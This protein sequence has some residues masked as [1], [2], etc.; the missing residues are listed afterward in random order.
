MTQP[1]ALSLSHE[2]ADA[3]IA[4]IFTFPGRVTLDRAQ[5][6]WSFAI[7]QAV[8]IVDG[9]MEGG[10]N[11]GALIDQWA[12][13][14][15][16]TRS[17]GGRP[18]SVSLRSILI[19]MLMHAIHRQS[20]TLRQMA[21]TVATDLDCDE[22][23][24]IGLPTQTLDAD[25]W[26]RRLDSAH[27]ALIAL[28]NP[29]PYPRYSAA[30][31]DLPPPVERITRHRK[32]TALQLQELDKFHESMADDIAVRQGRLDDLSFELVGNTTRMAAPLLT[33]FNG[34]IALDA[35]FTAMNGRNTLKDRSEPA[36]STIPEAGLYTRHGDHKVDEGPATNRAGRRARKEVKKFGFE[37]EVLITTGGRRIPDLILGVYLHRPGALTST[38]EVIF[39]RLSRLGLKARNCSVDRAYNNLKPENFHEILLQHGYEFVFDYPIDELGIQEN[40]TSGMLLDEDGKPKRDKRAEQNDYIMVEGTW[41]I[42]Y[43]PELLINAVKNSMRKPTDPR[44]IDSAKLKEFLDKRTK[45]Q[46]TRFGTRDADGYQR[47]T[48]PDPVLYIAYDPITA[49]IKTKPKARTVSIPMTVGLRWAQKYPYKS[50]EWRTAYNL[51]SAVERANARLKHPALEHLG[52]AFKRQFRGYAPTALAVALMAVSYNIGA[53]DHF[54]RAA[55]GINLAKTQHRQTRPKQRPHWTLIEG[56]QKQQDG[57][58]A[59]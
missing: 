7:A 40:F 37:T 19:V 51:R 12:S 8:Q 46:L 3:L 44:W 33:E 59:A 23:E 47:Y 21:D 58:A 30:D 11:I 29:Y 49:E 55:E 42:G 56:I 1:S 14:D 41:Y 34:D 35:T 26:Y 27:K 43:M 24:S 5:R 6:G 20:L 31:P 28:I 9:T 50:P 15:C 36:R 22:L 13:E 54:L 25:V 38:A 39:P 53:M 4:Q 48:L 2:E 32:L 52:N 45:Y 57:R 17:P 16:T 18:A 10:T